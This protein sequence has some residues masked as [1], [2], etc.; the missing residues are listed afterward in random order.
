MMFERVLLAGPC[1]GGEAS[2]A[3]RLARVLRAQGHAVRV[4]ADPLEEGRGSRAFDAALRAFRPTLLIWDV[5]AMPADAFASELAALACVKVALGQGALDAPPMGF[6]A[7][8]K[9][10][11]LDDANP[12]GGAGARMLTACPDAA[13]TDAVLSDATAGRAGILCSQPATPERVSVLER[14]QEA[15]ADRCFV[16]LHP[17]WDGYFGW[18]SF[19]LEGAYHA[20]TAR[21]AVYFAADDCP[22]ADMSMRAA[23]GCIIVAE[24]ALIEGDG[25]HSVESALIVFE[26]EGELASA[27]EGLEADGRRREQVVCEQ[28]EVLLHGPML[29]EDM[30]RLL[31]ELRALEGAAVAA[32]LD[33]P[34]VRVVLF[35]WFGARNFG[36][37][38][39]MQLVC[40]RVSER[41]PNSEIF[42]VGANPGEVRCAYGLDAAAPDEKHR[43]ACAL[44]GAA[45]VVYCGGLLFD[46]PMA[47]TAG[48]VELLFDPWIEPTGQAG[49]ALLAAERGARSVMLGI[50]AGPV[51]RLS[52]KR[53]IG[54]LG[55]AG[56]L[57]LPRDAET[58]AFLLESGVDSG[59]VR[60][61]ADLVL[62][63]ADYVRSR[64]TARARVGEEPYLTVSLRDWY[65]N[66]RGFERNLAAALDAV[67]EKTGLR[68]L[69]LPFDDCDVA[70]HRR[71]AEAM[72]VRDHVVLLDERPPEDELLGCISTS[73]LAIAMRLHCSVLH[74]ILGK[75]AIGLN[76]NDKIGAH[77]AGLG[78]LDSLFELA[79]D[80]ARLAARV[81]EILDAGPEALLRAVA[82][83]A[84]L[85]DEAYAELFAV[86]DAHAGGLRER[87]VYHPRTRNRFEIELAR[88]ARLV[89]GLKRQLEEARE[90]AR[91]LRSSRSFR[92]G[93]AFLAPFAAI[94]A[95]LRNR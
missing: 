25:L 55:R 75:P 24:K 18:H 72:V 78:Q 84:L 43:I 10:G 15:L 45:A 81:I 34:A 71:V 35:G 17:S 93:H 9:R 67:V 56:T 79:F 8:L 87:T 68:V 14:A 49:V 37:D 36:D 5:D 1:A 59:Q 27:L 19:G 80:P 7:V 40:E 61:R 26:D 85:V 42:V 44:E 69:F 6:D 66:P 88:E 21:Y 94:G 32:P 11:F 3:Y 48:D 91:A 95:A 12:A 70:I 23:E 86:I 58:A 83:K 54:L 57:F 74:Q 38:L 39:L 73:C 46:Q 30:P 16:G 82:E 28:R 33:S 20:R 50:G 41:Y 2:T 31:A 47:E 4:C 62:G 52:T 65:R 90:E 77:F 64:A 63:A 51:E 22:C 13:Y 89:H 29:E 60:Q 76:Y 53:A 92:L